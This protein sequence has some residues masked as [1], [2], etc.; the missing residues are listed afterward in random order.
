[1]S[2]LRLL[3]AGRSLESVRDAETRYRLTTQRLLPQFGPAKNP[4]SGLQGGSAASTAQAHQSAHAP[5]KPGAGNR[6]QPLWLR[7]AERV[8]GWTA[9]LTQRLTQPKPKPIKPAIPQFAN[10]AVQGELSLDRVRV[11]R[12]DLSDADLEVVPARTKLPPT[13]LSVKSARRFPVALE[14]VTTRLF[15]AGKM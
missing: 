13:L 10:S 8:N 7:V 1:M 9:M 2:L 15:G 11:M 12:N 4:F 14:R 3:T 6:Q 5:V